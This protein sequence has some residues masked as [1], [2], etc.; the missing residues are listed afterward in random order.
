M[1]E[2]LVQQL[3]NWITLGCI[4]ALLAIGFSLIFGVLNVIHF[5][6]GDV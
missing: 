3:V 2:L 4:Y 6:H 1:A 5:S